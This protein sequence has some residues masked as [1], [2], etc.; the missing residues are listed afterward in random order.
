MD[1]HNQIS[2]TV[3]DQYENLF[4]D[5]HADDLEA[6]Q[7]NDDSQR[8]ADLDVWPPSDRND[9]TYGQDTPQDEP[10]SQQTVTSSTPHRL[11][12]TQ[13]TSFKR[14]QNSE[15]GRLSKRA[16][17]ELAD[18]ADGDLRSSRARYL[19]T[20]TYEEFALRY[21]MLVP[22][23]SRTSEIRDLASKILTKVLGASKSEGLD[24]YQLGLTEIFF[25]IDILAFLENLRT[26][27]L[28]HSATVIQ[29]NLKA[30]YYRCKYL[31]AR[32]T[33]LLIQSVTR[34]YLAWKY[35]QETCKIKATTI[36]QRV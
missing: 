11:D 24:K 28:D 19:T 33:I 23:S 2:T 31:A 4:V 27:R 20:W 26:A 5:P 34:R 9:D 21:Y 35:T 30:N 7:T 10:P 36:I 14:K 8:S 15:D 22:S 6:E 32:N 1:S 25:R 16:H 13:N 12:T 29:K 17:I 18:A 3:H